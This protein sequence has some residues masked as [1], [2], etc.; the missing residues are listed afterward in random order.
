MIHAR[1]EPELKALFDALASR[2]GLSYRELIRL[3]TDEHVERL[4]AKER[5]AVEQLAKKLRA[6]L[7]AKQPGSVR[8][9]SRSPTSPP[10]D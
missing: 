10:R 4:D 3:L 9:G 7:E 6:A 5:R 8:S 1:V 2:S